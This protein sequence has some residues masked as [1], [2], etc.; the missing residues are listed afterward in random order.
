[1]GAARAASAI[2]LVP[3]RPWLRIS[4]CLDSRGVRM[5]SALDGFANL[6]DRIANLV[7][8]PTDSAL[9]LPHRLVDL[10]LG[11]QL[12]VAGQRAHSLLDLALGLIDGPV[13]FVPVQHVQAPRYG[14]FGLGREASDDRP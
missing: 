9:D 14:Q 8:R 2:W 11:L 6:R 1:M 5:V 10:A 3:V 13:P 7:A 4:L 12:A